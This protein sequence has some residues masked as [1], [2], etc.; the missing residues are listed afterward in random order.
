MC[1]WQLLKQKAAAKEAKNE[2]KEA[3]A[4]AKRE[5]SASAEATKKEAADAA[6]RMQDFLVNMMQMMLG[7]DTNPIQNTRESP[8]AAAPP[9]NNKG[10]C[11]PCGK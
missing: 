10:C 2:A 1:V 3:A 4:E 7:Q 6:I 5:A 11:P 8:L 9:K